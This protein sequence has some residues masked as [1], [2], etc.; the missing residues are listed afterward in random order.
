MK[1]PQTPPDYLGRS[2]DDDD[3]LR[4]APSTRFY[5]F[6]FAVIVGLAAAGV[7][8]LVSGR[9]QDTDNLIGRTGALIIGPAGALAAIDIV[10]AWVRP[11]LVV[12]AGEI[13]GRTLRERRFRFSDS[14][15]RSISVQRRSGITWVV[16][17]P[18]A[19]RDPIRV[20]VNT[21]DVAALEADILRTLRGTT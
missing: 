7:W 21:T 18:Q 13:R 6:W 17:S 12:S 3:R 5:A 19:V 8:L 11:A 15:V 16:I 10:M 1:Y 14:D 4:V 2:V 20:P 9:A